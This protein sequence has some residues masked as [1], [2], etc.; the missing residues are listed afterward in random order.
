MKIPISEGTQ[1]C[2][3]SGQ[4]AYQ[5]QA[6]RN[7]IDFY[8]M[9]VKTICTTVRGSTC[10][11]SDIPAWNGLESSMTSAWPFCRFCRINTG[12]G[13][14][15]LECWAITRARMSAAASH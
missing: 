3:C 13:S 6:D 14:N 15:R 4:A 11:F 10:V 9:T 2:V 8:N 1:N 7:E 12:L 5:K